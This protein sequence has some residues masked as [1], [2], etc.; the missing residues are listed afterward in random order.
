MR[1]WNGDFAAIDWEYGVETGMA[2]L[3]APHGLIEVAGVIRRTDP[4]RARRAITE[5]L[6][7]QL[8]PAEYARHAASLA[9]LSA[10]NML[11]TWYAFPA[12]ADDFSR[13]LAAFI[14]A[15]H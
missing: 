5:I 8:L 4:A 7:T 14:A 2:F 6:R 10:L 1:Y 13:W 11:I 9:S 3:E 15:D 12:P